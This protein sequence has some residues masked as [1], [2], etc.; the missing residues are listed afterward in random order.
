MVTRKIERTHPREILHEEFVERV[1]L[2]A[3]APVKAPG[4]RCLE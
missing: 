4:A 3:Y 2:I 1:G